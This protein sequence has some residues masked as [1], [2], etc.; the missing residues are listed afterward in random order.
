MKEI[1][2]LLPED[3][4]ISQLSIVCKLKNHARALKFE[5]LL[6]LVE[7]YR[8]SLVA[9]GEF[10]SVHYGRFYYKIIL[11]SDDCQPGYRR[12][13]G[14][15]AECEKGKYQTKISQPS[16]I[17]CPSGTTTEFTGSTKPEQCISMNP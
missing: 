8:N 5:I 12:T 6:S 14:E 13:A 17:D 2:P 4:N 10:I 16:C 9:E 7:K 3:H 11:F 1:L 15:C